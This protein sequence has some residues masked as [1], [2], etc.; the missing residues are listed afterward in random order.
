MAETA[1]R[2]GQARFT[3]SQA[4]TPPPV[5]GGGVTGGVDQDPRTMVQNSPMNS[6]QVE[7]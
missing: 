2:W 4:E 1:H 3:L 5:D 6:F 7:W